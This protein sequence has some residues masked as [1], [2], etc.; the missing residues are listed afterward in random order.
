MECWL[1]FEREPD[2]HVG[3]GLERP[4]FAVDV[5]D[6]LTLELFE[7]SKVVR[8]QEAANPVAINTDAACVCE[9]RNDD[10]L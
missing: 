2:Q 5:G 4:G 3:I 7:I 9:S 10:C 6:G 1:I 8:V